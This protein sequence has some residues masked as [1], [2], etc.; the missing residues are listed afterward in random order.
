MKRQAKP[1]SLRA[2][3]KQQVA[4]KKMSSK[5]REIQKHLNNLSPNLR[6]R[7]LEV[8]AAR[9][10]G[11]AKKFNLRKYLNEKGVDYTLLP[12]HT[13]FSK[14]KQ[15][16]H[17][18]HRA[19]LPMSVCAPR[20]QVKVEPDVPVRMTLVVGDKPIITTGLTTRSNITPRLHNWD[21]IYPK[22]QVLIT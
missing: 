18:K 17:L 9:K 10:K 20:K 11:T 22:N 3:K 1:A 14:P 21:R 5:D 4:G 7:A 16:K 2:A 19:Q 12:P 15:G 6:K 8:S 13:R